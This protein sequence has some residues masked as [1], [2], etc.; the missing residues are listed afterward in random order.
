MTLTDLPPYISGSD[1]SEAAARSVHPAKARRERIRRCIEDYVA[2]FPLSYG[3]TCD[4]VE[5]LT[6]YCHQ[7]ASARI[8]EL[9]QAGLIEDTGLRRLTRSKRSARV[10]RACRKDAA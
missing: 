3:L 4:Q 5:E 10:Y 8:R 1:T 6:G 2:V 7:T 9:C